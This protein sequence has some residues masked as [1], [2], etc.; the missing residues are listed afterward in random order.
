MKK[1]TLLQKAKEMKTY[2][3][4][5]S[6]TSTATKEQIELAL[7]WARDEITLSQLSRVLWGEK[8]KLSKSAG[9]RAL[10]YIASWLKAGILRGIIK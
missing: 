4:S 6:L 1:K 7:G 2:M 9:G 3:R 10:Y 5:S 8:T